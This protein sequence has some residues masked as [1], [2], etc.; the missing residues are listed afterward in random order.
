MADLQVLEDNDK[1]F[2]SI[3]VAVNEL[4]RDRCNRDDVTQLGADV[5]VGTKLDSLSCYSEKQRG[6]DHEPTARGAIEA[7]AI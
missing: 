5:D 2:C 1:S 6:T 3:M 7:A 4:D